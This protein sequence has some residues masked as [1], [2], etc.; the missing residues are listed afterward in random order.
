MVRKIILL[1]VILLSIAFQLIA[2]ASDTRIEIEVSSPSDMYY[3]VPAGANGVLIFGEAERK[4]KDGIP[5]DFTLYN[6]RFEKEW[7]LP[8]T[9]PKRAHL[10]NKFYDTERN[11][12]YMLFGIKRKGVYQSDFEVLS[13]NA[14]TKEHKSIK[15]NF[16]KKTV[17]NDF[18]AT[19]GVVTFGGAVI[20]NAGDFYLKGLFTT[21]LLFV[22]A[23]FGSMNY[24]LMPVLYRADFNNMALIQPPLDLKGNS[25]ITS[26]SPGPDKGNT[27]VLLSSKKSKTNIAFNL[28]RFG[29]THSPEEIVTLNIQNSYDITSGRILNDNSGGM[30]VVGSYYTR[31]K[32]YKESYLRTGSAIT[33]PALGIYIAH[34]SD[35]KQ[36]YLKTYS[37]SKFENFFSFLPRRQQMR[38]QKRALRRETSMSGYSILMHNPIQTAEGLVVIGEAFYPEYE[39]D[40]YTEFQPNGTTVQRCSTI[41]VGYRFTHALAAGLSKEG[42]LLWD[43]CFPVMEILT[44]DL[45]QQVKDFVDGE[46]I[47]LLY[48]YDGALKSMVLSGKNKV[49]P[50]TVQEI[51]TGVSGDN[52][53]ANYAS[54]IEHWYDNYFIAYGFQKI[55]NTKASGKS[56]RRVFYFS[57]IA[58]Q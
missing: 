49:S 43:N 40:C 33:S 8:I 17:L 26:V 10:I 25:H 54:G 24:K 58:Y 2:Q 45:K 7:T 35:G 38:A 30:Y 42:E 47:L 5:F 50:R 46:E 56:R 29:Q 31:P 18:Y 48:S 15:G 41:F 4:D 14:A 36:D 51:D 53:K 44:F 23:F 20:P 3:A 11:E 28:M 32:S 16:G 13:L 39:T 57:K 52:V 21:A 34:V 1:F 19:D 22:P 9:V 37:F 6:T 12:L 55:K 27:T